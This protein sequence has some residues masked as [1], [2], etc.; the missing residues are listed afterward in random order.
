NYHCAVS[1]GPFTVESAVASLTVIATNT[2]YAQAV[3]A[4]GPLLYYLTGEGG[5]S[6]ALDSSRHGSPGTRTTVPPQPGVGPEG[7]VAAGLDGTGSRGHITVPTLVHPVTGSSS[8]YA[9]TVEAWVRL[10][11][12]NEDSDEFGLSGIFTGNGWPSGSF[13]LVAANANRFFFGVHDSSGGGFNNDYPVTDPAVFTTN[14]WLHLAAVFNT[15]NPP[16]FRFYTNGVL[17][18]LINLDNAPAAWLTNSHIG[19]WLGLDGNLSRFFDG[20]IDEVAVYAA[21]LPPARIAAHYQS[22]FPA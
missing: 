17:A 20:Q 2:A 10:N 6:T 9:L 1:A 7:G 4:D 19:S 21:A 22:V 18:K 11:Q 5:G 16:S 8:F 13:Q 15:A 14:V 12:W 3:L